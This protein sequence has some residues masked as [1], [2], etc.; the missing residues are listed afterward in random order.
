MSEARAIA[1]ALAAPHR[2]QRLPNGTYLVPCPVPS[3]G[4]G[5]GDRNPSLR[6]GDGQT[7]LLVHCYA[8]CDR[9]DVL[10]ELRHRGFIKERNARPA[11]NPTP[12]PA[13]RS[14][15]DHERE[16]HRKAAWLWSQRRPITGSLAETYLRSRDIT[17]PLP[18]TLAFLPA[19]KPDRHP[20]MIAAFTLVDEPEPGMPGAP[21]NVEAVHLTL[22]RPDGNG[23]VEFK[24]DTNGKVK[25]NKIIIGRP[26]G[27]PIMLAP[28]NDV[29]GLAI[30]EGIEDALTVHMATG[31]GAWAAGSA[32][33]MPP[34]TAHVPSYIEC[35]TVFVDANDAGRR[36]SQEFASRL[37]NQPIEVILREL[38]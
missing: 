25:P 23:K 18:A 1:D 15:D 14:G 11:P 28:P 2:A 8:G 37:R 30:T 7:R 12:K 22:L 36:Y 31:L 6:I 29:M 35:V 24:P 19:N 5:H 21:R 34:I 4:K 32:T 27:R 20:A 26:L 17:C 38:R 16:Q 10:D 9:L 3:H 13:P 33:H